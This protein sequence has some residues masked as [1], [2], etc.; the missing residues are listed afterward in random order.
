MAVM[1][2]LDHYDVQGCSIGHRCRISCIAQV[3]RRLG[4][5]RVTVSTL[6]SPTGAGL[7]QWIQMPCIQ[8]PQ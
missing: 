2:G 4:G 5:G 6:S 3:A 8:A 1:A 7:I